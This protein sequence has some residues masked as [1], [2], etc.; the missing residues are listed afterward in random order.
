MRS[1]SHFSPLAAGLPLLLLAACARM[2]A[3]PTPVSAS[4]AAAVSKEAK[5]TN[6]TGSQIRFVED[7]W[8]GAVERAKSERKPLFVDS[9]ATWCHSCLSMQRFVFN[10]P[11]LRPMKDAVVWLA[12]ETEQEH[13]RGFVEKYPADGL[14]T[15][16]LLDPDSGEVLGR[17][18][19]SGTA[20]EMRTF[21]QEGVRAYA[22]K[23]GG[24]GQT[25]AALAEREGDAAQLRRDYAA[26][27]AAYKRAFE[28]SPK[29]DP[30]R[31]ERLVKLASTL[32]RRGKHA[33]ECVA[34]GEQE[35]NGM[36]V[37]PAG[38]DFATT[39]AGCAEEVLKADKTDAR[40]RKLPALAEAYLLSLLAKV[41]APLSADDRS[42]VLANLAD[43]Q[44][45][46]GRKPAAVETMRRREKLLEEAAAA[47]PD[48]VTAATF[49]A[50]RTDTY[51]F[52]EELPKA[53][54][55]LSKRETEIP[56]DYNPPARLARVLLLE[57]KLLEAEAAVERALGQMTNGPR[58]VGIL[59]LK[60][61]IL[62]ALGKPKEAVL[63]EQLAV[64]RGLPATQRQ[65]EAEAKLAAA[66]EPAAVSAA[67]K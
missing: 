30:A 56:G 62:D 57:K 48:P 2:A 65:P 37:T 59:G 19:G 26:A 53:E 9:W 32:G 46:D 36:P 49:D 16:L 40:A 21:V 64:L 10:D 66:L 29:D 14:P 13:N 22:A 33:D 25:A 47:A 60:A 8:A 4:T 55:L 20:N 31:P 38:A 5:A 15:F 50:H 11:G 63:R 44:E 1:L 23:S 43:L 12:I 27:G 3:A 6:A 42:D 58:R 24:P 51:V 39:V 67:Q 18:L 35:L 54:A 7:D 41:D 61:K 45:S 28:Q 52:L 34:L 17:W